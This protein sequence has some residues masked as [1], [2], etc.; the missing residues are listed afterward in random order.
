MPISVKLRIERKI[1]TV[2]PRGIEAT[3]GMNEVIT[4]TAWA[5]AQRTCS[6]YLSEDIIYLAWLRLEKRGPKHA[7]SKVAIQESPPIKHKGFEDSSPTNNSE[8]YP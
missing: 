2:V 1:V 6:K 8:P 4:A 5:L 3:E 7:V